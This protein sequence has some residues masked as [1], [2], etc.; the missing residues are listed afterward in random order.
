[1]FANARPESERFRRRTATVATALDNGV[2]DIVAPTLVLAGE[3]DRVVPAAVT[4]AMA[5]R[6]HGADAVLLPAIGH[7][8]AMQAP[9]VLAHHLIRFLKPEGAKA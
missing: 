3:L 1:V 9:E 4:L 2:A 8:A 5:G 7:V 6:I